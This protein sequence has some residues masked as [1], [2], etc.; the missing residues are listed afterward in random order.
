MIRELTHNANRCILT[1]LALVLLAAMSSVPA[2]AATYKHHLMKRCS[3]NGEVSANQAR[4]LVRNYLTELGYTSHVRAG[5]GGARVGKVT[6]ED[7]L[8]AIQVKLYS[9]SLAS[10]KYRTV[11][12]DTRCGL[13]AVTRTEANLFLTEVSK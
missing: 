10:R 8:W 5:G 12:V 9:S 2:T 4:R 13:L 7:G 3:A 1:I 6:L 11:F